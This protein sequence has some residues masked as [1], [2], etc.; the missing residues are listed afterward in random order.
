MLITRTQRPQTPPL[1]ATA[2]KAAEQAEQAP[3]D[4]A[5]INLRTVVTRGAFTVGGGMGGAGLGAITGQVMKN[6]SG[7][8]VFSTFGGVA[9]AIGGAAAGFAASRGDVSKETLVRTGGAWLGASVGSAAGMWVVGAAGAALTANGASGLFAANGALI[10]TAVGGLL[11]AAAPFT[12]VEG[13]GTDF[14]KDAAVAGLGGTVGLLLG[15]LPQSGLPAQFAHVAAPVPFIGAITL[16]LTGLHLRN[17]GFDNY[18]PPNKGLQKAKNSAWAGTVG[19]GLGSAAGLLAQHMGGSA[20][21]TYAGPAV[22]A[23]VATLT[24]AGDG[25][26]NALTKSALTLGLTSLGATAGDVIGHGLTALT[27]HSVYRSLGAAAGAVN[28]AAAGISAAGFDTKH[29]LS[30]VTGL[31][32]GTASGALVG[33]GISALTGQEIWKVA[34]PAVGSAFGVL[35]GLALSLNSAEKP[36]AE[37]TR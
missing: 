34:M 6:L 28:G 36:A 27:G 12:G 2:P 8:P 26:S 15:G 5:E 7:S 1:S 13:K 19:Y 23:A 20:A 37:M 4:K 16:G 17:N 14:L 24:A 35:T 9:G 30:I 25:E 33:A 29:G 11:G 22:G 10:G 3:K 18:D 31:A 21:Y 32:G